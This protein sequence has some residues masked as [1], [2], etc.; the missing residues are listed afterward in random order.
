M[1]IS[2]TG[3]HGTGK[4]TLVTELLKIHTRFQGQVDAFSDAGVM[5]SKGQL[6]VLDKESLQLLFFARHLYRIGTNADMLTDR[7]IL[8]ALCYAKYEYQKGTIRK[9]VFSY[10]E[11]RSLSVLNCFYDGLIWLSPEFELIGEDKRPVDMQYQQDIHEIF[12]DYIETKVTIPV[13]QATGSI[14]QRVRDVNEFIYNLEN[15]RDA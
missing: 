6:D 1:I 9:S 10:L 13:L 12:R 4:T 7:S 2:L 11:D 8:D 14:T 5:Y 3:T 15:S